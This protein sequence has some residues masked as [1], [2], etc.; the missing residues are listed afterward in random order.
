MSEP[1]LFDDVFAINRDLQIDAAEIEGVPAVVIDNYLANPEAAR[2]ITGATPAANWKMTPDGRNFTDY[3]D[4]R[5]R[6]PVVFPCPLVDAARQIVQKVYAIETRP[7]NPCV[8]INWFKQVS[9]RRADSAVPHHDVVGTSPR[10]FTCL[11]Y[12]NREDECSGG[13]EFFRFRGS[14]SLVLDRDFDE[15]AKNDP[16]IVETGKDYWPVDRDRYWEP[17]GNAPMT[18]GRMIIFPSEFFHAAWHPEDSFHEFPR[19]TLAFWL[20]Q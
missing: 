19:L 18:P 5:L 12:L 15:T 17:V 16:G 11:I 6:I 1:Y 7:Q 2:E 9:P 10:T 14:G 8:D 20:H 3:Y 4:C 13:T